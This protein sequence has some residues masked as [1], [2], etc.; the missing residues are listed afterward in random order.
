MSCSRRR[1]KPSACRPVWPCSW[2]VRGPWT[3]GAHARTPVA[4]YYADWGNWLP[5][6]TAYEERRPSYFGTPAVNLVW[7][8]DVSLGQILAEGLERT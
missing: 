5:I 2:P 1:R 7:A 3:R 4:N 6:M 8:L